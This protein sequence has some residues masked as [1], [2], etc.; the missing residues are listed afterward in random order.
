MKIGR[1]TIVK[2]SLTLFCSFGA[3]YGGSIPKKSANAIVLKK[4]CDTSLINKL[5]RKGK[6]KT[7]FAISKKMY[8]KCPDENHKRLYAKLAFWNKNISAAYSLINAFNPQEK[9]YR[10]IYAVKT[11]Q[12]IKNGITPKIPD[13]LQNNYDILAARINL[14]IKHKNFA[15][16]YKIS[17]KLYS[18]YHSKE[19]L[20]IKANLLLW[21]H[22]YKKSLKYF[23]ILKNE[24]KVKEIEHAIL[25]EKTEQIN[26][27]ILKALKNSNKQKAR[28]LF[29]N[30]N[31]EEKEFYRKKYPQNACKVESTR[32][33]GIG[34]EHKSHSSRTYR[35][36][37]NY[38]EFSM[39]IQRYTVYAKIQNTNRYNFSDSQL[40]LEIY[41]PA[42]K[43]GYWGYFSIS[44]T[45]NA[46]FY[47][48]IS[49]GAN[50]FKDLN[51][52]EFGIGY[53]Y[54]RYKNRDSDM[55]HIE[56]THYFTDKISLKEAYYYELIS[57][58]QAFEM[59]FAYTSPC[60][61]KLKASYL[62]SN[63]NELLSDNK[64]LEN[65]GH[66]FQLDFEYPLT[67]HISI[68]GALSWERTLNRHS[69][70]RGINLFLRKYW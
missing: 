19:A 20:E 1:G 65:S 7:A 6:I 12:D 68:G 10:Q 52:E 59:E 60:H 35:D 36:H 39:P 30:L 29:K 22:K 67:R 47:S 45:P 44:Y 58:S 66:H 62:Y 15:K 33:I 61:L 24:K 53:I 50:L 34:F 57:R 40:Y 25:K 42:F 3:L 46:K 28:L 17:K 23:K 38:L 55:F 49:L 2:I 54:S 48:R 13:F 56:W 41:P 16:A 9:L 70:A 5:I 18:L 51:K 32:M 63:S 64:I 21:M 43:K 37:S 4:V 14:E 31:T 26:S 11:L 27:K 69:T 8:I